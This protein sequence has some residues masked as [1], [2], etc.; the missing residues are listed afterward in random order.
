MSSIQQVQHFIGGSWVGEPT[1]ERRNPADPAQVV[2]IT[3]VGTPADVD[4]AL[5]AAR[6]AQPGWAARPAPGRGAVLDRASQILASRAE[7]VARD[8]TREEG[9]TLAEARGEVRRA[10]DVL[11]YYGGEGW[12][13]SGQ[14]IPSD[15]TGTL[16]YTKREP[17]GIA[18]VVTPW[19]F[20]I[21]IPAWK[22][23][24]ALISGNAV[25]F[26]PAT[27]TSHSGTHLVRALVEAGLPDGVLNVVHGRGARVGAALVGDP[28]VDAV[29]FTG[30][31]TV[32]KGIHRAVS[33]RMG[34]VQLEMGGKNPI[35][36]TAGANVELAARVVATSAFAVTGQ[37]CTAASRVIV[38]SSIADEL[39]AA[40]G[41][42][43]ERYRPGDGLDDRVLM[44]PVVDEKQ[45]E[46]D[47]R[48]VQVAREEG[49]EV[50]V[51]G[52][53]LDGQFFAPTMVTGVRPEHT[54]AQR[55]VFGPVLAVIEI[56]DFDEAIEVANAVPFGLTAGI[57]TN[58]LAMAHRFVDR[59]QAGVVKVNRPT[60]GLELNVPF[61]GIKESSTGTF[62]EQ[63]AVATEFYTWSKSVYM[64]SE[65]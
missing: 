3:A 39:V 29:S 43:I 25:V 4:A 34:R 45:L 59:I 60:V 53:V 46:T 7:R 44:G 32:G 36:V 14:V 10:V 47:R 54:I 35:I 40:L 50:V 31:T 58:D 12:R 15:T 63:G 18:A 65:G 38:P 48:Y 9:K 57:C 49:G 41:G 52:D 30:S 6:Q 8:L 33:A 56:D 5:A 2:T 13:L 42:E 28:R 64:G 21:A 19:N 23:A 26:K 20:P 22:M 62:R 16:I 51:G 1:L 24:P 61:G 27:L 17:I 55:E 37:A 11:R